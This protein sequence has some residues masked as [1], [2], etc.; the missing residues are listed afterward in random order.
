MG[1]LSLTDMR[2]SL[3]LLLNT[4]DEVSTST[5]A[6]QARLDQYLNW[7]Y[8]RVSHPSIFEHV[9]LQT[10]TTL[11]LVTNQQNYTL[12][13]A[14]IFAIDHIYYAAQN[15]RLYPMSRRALSD[16][17]VPSGMPTR[18]AHWGTTVWLDRVPTTAENGQVLTVFGWSLPT[19]LAA[20]PASLLHALWDEVIV[21]GGA[22]RG[23]RYL[24]DLARSDTY[25]EEYAALVNEVKDT[26]TVE[27]K[28]IGWPS[29]MSVQEYQRR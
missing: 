23:W 5:A 29:P 18:Y 27:A 8:A 14:T 24:G 16:Q 9:E 2:S 26:L 6:G 12:A 25:R 10:S 21:I 11:T 1:I 13:T 22:W 20:S 28:D 3:A 17:T 15:K 4:R 19:A 7:A